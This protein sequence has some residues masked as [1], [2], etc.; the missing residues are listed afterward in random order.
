MRKLLSALSRGKGRAFRRSSFPIDQ[1]T[2]GYRARSYRPQRTTN[3]SED[4]G[5]VPLPLA[6][7][8]DDTA[9]AVD[10]ELGDLSIHRTIEI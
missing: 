7:A 10:G 8:V 9:A 5:L 4:T 2:I 6:K 3:D 1:Q